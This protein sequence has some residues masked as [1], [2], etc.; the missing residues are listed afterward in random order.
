MSLTAKLE[1]AKLEIAE[2]NEI[3][4]VSEIKAEISRLDEAQGSL[5]YQS[6]KI[7]GLLEA[8]LET[9]AKSGN[10]LA[11]LKDKKQELDNLFATYEEM[12]EAD[13]AFGAEG[14]LGEGISKISDVKEDLKAELPD[15]DLKFTGGKK[16]GK[17]NRELALEK[18]T[19]HL[20]SLKIE[21]EKIE[22]EKETKYLQTSEGQTQAQIKAENAFQCQQEVLWNLPRL[23]SLEKISQLKISPDHLEMA[24][25]YGVELTQ[26]TILNEWKKMA[27][28]VLL[29]QTFSKNREQINRF[30]KNKS[31]TESFSEYNE[32]FDEVKESAAGLKTLED[33]VV[34]TLAD[35]I[36]QNPEVKKKFHNYGLGGYSL[37]LELKKSLTGYDDLSE[38]EAAD[39]PAAIAY[40][41]I[42]HLLDVSAHDPLRKFEDL[43]KYRYFAGSQGS[44][45]DVFGQKYQAEDFDFFDRGDYDPD[46]LLKVADGL[47]SLVEALQSEIK[48]EGTNIDPKT[49]LARFGKENYTLLK[50]LPQL[51]SAEAKVVNFPGEYVEDERLNHKYYEDEAVFNEFNVLEKQSFAKIDKLLPLRWLEEELDQKYRKNAEVWKVLDDKVDVSRLLH[52]L[53]RNK[54]YH[55]KQSISVSANPDGSLRLLD[56]SGRQALANKKADYLRLEKD[57]KGY[58][59]NEIAGIASEIKRGEKQMFNKKDKLRTLNDRLGT[60]QILSSRTLEDKIY[61]RFSGSDN[62]S[63]KEAALAV[64]ELEAI[65]K[66]VVSGRRNLIDQQDLDLQV[67]ED[68]KDLNRGLYQINTKFLSKYGDLLAGVATYEG[69][70]SNLKLINISL[71]SQLKEKHAGLIKDFSE[72]S[73]R[74]AELVADYNRQ[75]SREGSSHI[76]PV[77]SFKSDLA[78]Y[79]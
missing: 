3:E 50:E 49:F 13:K 74:Y 60:C 40:E 27:D 67:R 64:E 16:G 9:Y 6:Q 57:Y 78:G 55:V 65:K 61:E 30:Q 68:E 21:I 69:L 2:Q 23:D 15:L 5:L 42:H 39:S 62:P 66:F 7:S 73:K 22:K 28:D 14:T 26:E 8:L 33:A 32:R 76:I 56:T 1:T 53:E 51:S 72:K 31:F 38:N 43:F 17:S 47:N 41:Y 59:K 44:S 20:E 19:S 36:A 12:L 70:I 48:A 29:N 77:L 18:I 35:I 11:N 24:G 45:A 75:Y 58:L 63:F 71:F 79:L 10:N 37:G 34:L 54:E 4:K 52:R 25:R 46:Y